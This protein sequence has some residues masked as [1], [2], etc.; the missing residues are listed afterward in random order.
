[1]RFVR[2]YVTY[3]NVICPNLCYTRKYDVWCPLILHTNMCNVR[4]YVTHEYIWN[5]FYPN[6]YPI[7]KYNVRTYVTHESTMF[8]VQY[9]ITYDNVTRKHDILC[10]NLCYIR[11]C[12]M[13]ESMLHR[14]NMTSRVCK[15]F[16][17]Q[18]C[19]MSVM[20]HMNMRTVLSELMLCC[21]HT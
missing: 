15:L 10:P 9:N 2:I 3:E 16:Y 19:V 12:V 5:V 14:K 11:K 7:L 20:I 17:I 21:S 1:M 18:K 6:I 4:I 8:L 13:S